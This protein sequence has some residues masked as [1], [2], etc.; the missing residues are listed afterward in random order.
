MTVWLASASSWTSPRH[1]IWIG[2][3]GPCTAPLSDVAAALRPLGCV[4]VPISAREVASFYD[5]FAN[6]VLWPISHYLVDKIARDAGEHWAA[7]VA[8][9]QRFADVVAT[10]CDSADDVVWIHDYQVDFGCSV[11]SVGRVGGGK[12]IT[13]HAPRS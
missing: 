8:V 2:W 13:A 6:G 5:G 12:L 11:L 4:P 1:S 7:F 3:A 9:N 10:H